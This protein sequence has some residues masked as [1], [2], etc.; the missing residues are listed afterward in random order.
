MATNPDLRGK[1]ALVT[2]ASRGIGADVARVLAREGMSVLLAART[3]HEGEF[4]VPGSLAETVDSIVAAGGQAAAHRCDLADEADV[5]ALWDWAVAEA[6]HIDVV[7]NNAGISPPGTIENMN[8]RHFHLGFQINVASPGLLS[9]L[10]AP[11]M[12]AL[13]GGVI[14]NVTSGASRGPGAGPYT[15]KAVRGTVYGLTKSALERMTQGMAA[16]L[17]E[18]N[19]SVNAI[20]PGKQIWV[21][22]TIYVASQRPGF[23]ELDLTGRRKDGTIMGDACVAIA[24]ADHAQFTG[25]VLSDE[26]TLTKL[27]G[28]TSFDKYATY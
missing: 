18:D 17:C 10:A 21:G 4:R 11:H 26:E 8:W 24:R 13:G 28:V 2:G 19:I 23:A 20:K 9:R 3:E 7:V 22:G 5:T 12:R 27:T 1:V 15:E 14:V 25:N 16:E 6:G